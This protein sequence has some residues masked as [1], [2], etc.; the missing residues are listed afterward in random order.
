MTEDQILARVAHAQA[1]RDLQAAVELLERIELHPEN[2]TRNTTLKQDVREFLATWAIRRSSAAGVGTSGEKAMSLD[3]TTGEMHCTIR[4]TAQFR[5]FAHRPQ[6]HDPVLQQAWQSLESG[7]LHWRD[8]PLAYGTDEDASGVAPTPTTMNDRYGDGSD[9]PCCPKCGYC[10][11]CGD[12]AAC[13]CGVAPT[14]E[15]QQKGGA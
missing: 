15:D 14:P 5:W 11:K 7:D 9:H 13:G 8:I 12:C 10:V 1:L 6:D 3:F 2:M 4:P